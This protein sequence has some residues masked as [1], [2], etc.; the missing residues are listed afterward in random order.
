MISSDVQTIMKKALPMMRSARAS[1]PCP[2]A[3]EHSETPPIP[4]RF[5]HA[6]T[7]VTTGSDSPM[8]VSASDDAPEIWPM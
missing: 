6:S 5:A 2:R 1:S 8:P 3:M 4:N 7:M